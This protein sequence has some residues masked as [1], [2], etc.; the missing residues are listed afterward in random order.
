MKHHEAMTQEMREAT[1]R[2]DRWS[3]AIAILVLLLGI[4]G[5]IIAAKLAE[6]HR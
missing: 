1:R 2:N 4:V 3:G 5:P 6:G